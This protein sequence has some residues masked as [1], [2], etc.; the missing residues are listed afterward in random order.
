MIDFSGTMQ[1]MLDPSNCRF[2]GISTRNLKDLGDP[3]DQEYK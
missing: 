2:I 1:E 3:L